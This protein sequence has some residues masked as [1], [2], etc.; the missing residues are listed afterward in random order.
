MKRI[1]SSLVL[2]VTMLLSSAAFAAITTYRSTMSGPAEAP[3][4]TSPAYGIATIFINDADMTMSLTLPFIDL[5]DGSTAAHLHCCTPEPLIGSAPV[6]LP[7]RDFPIYVRAG[8][9]ERVI[10]L[11]DAGIYDAAFLGAHG[12][13][14]AAARDFLLMGINAGQAYLNVHSGLYPA[15]EIRG[16]LVQVAQPVPEPSAWLMLGVGLAGLGLYARRKQR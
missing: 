9:Y 6:A 10:D 3:P 2:L 4:N 11:T 8:L 13:T 5:Q 1:V 12:G 14:A 15:G 16:F 7:F